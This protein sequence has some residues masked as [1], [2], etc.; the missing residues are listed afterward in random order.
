MSNIFTEHAATAWISDLYDNRFQP[1]RGLDP[2]RQANQVQDA[3]DAVKR[4]LSRVSQD[5]RDAVLERAK[6]L[7]IEGSKFTRWPNVSEILAALGS[8]MPKAQPG[9]REKLSPDTLQWFRDYL[10]RGYRPPSKYW[11]SDAAEQMLTQGI[12]DLETLKRSAWVDMSIGQRIRW[13]ET[14]VASGK[15]SEGELQMLEQLKGDG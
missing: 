5:D 9:E 14:R 12:I 13:L 10:R 11:D 6:V 3:V 7:L 1:P 15:A 8:S 4:F 2:E